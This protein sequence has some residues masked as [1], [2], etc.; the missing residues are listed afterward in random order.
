MVHSAS[1]WPGRPSSRPACGTARMCCAVQP[2][3]VGPTSPWS[4]LKRAGP[5]P[6]P[7]LPGMRYQL[8]EEKNKVRARWNLSPPADPNTHKHAHICPLV[9][10]AD[11]C[12]LSGRQKG[13]AHTVSRRRLLQGSASVQ[14]TRCSTPACCASSLDSRLTL[15]AGHLWRRCH[16]PVHFGGQSG[17]STSHAGAA[18]GPDQVC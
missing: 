14:Y 3:G 5:A 7:V 9:A 10:R 16:P 6:P 13:A 12:K 17:H 4:D 18:G 2:T 8:D 1:C 15:H 11:R